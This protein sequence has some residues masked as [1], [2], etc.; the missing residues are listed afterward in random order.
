MNRTLLVLDDEPEA[1]KG[2]QVFLGAN[3]RASSASTVASSRVQA[4]AAPIPSSTSSG[5]TYEVLCASTGEEAVQ[6]IRDRLKEGRPVAGGFFDVKLGPGMD[7]IATVAEAKK[8]DP[9]IRCAIVTAYQD[10]SVDDLHRIFGEDF[11][12]HWDYLN[13]PFSKGEIVQK[14]RQMIGAWNRAKQ[15][16]ELHRQLIGSERLAAVGQVARGIGHEF[17][18]ILL[19]IMGKADL[20]LAETDLTKVREHLQVVLK[21]SER[22]GVIVRNLQSFSKPSAKKST[23]RLT[24]PLEESLSLVRHELTKASVTVESTF[25]AGTLPTVTIDRGMFAQV[26]LNLMINAMHAMSPKGGTLTLRASPESR[27]GRAGCKVEIADSGTGISP[28]VLPRIFEPAFST[29][30]DQGSGLGLS[31][32]KEIVDAHGGELT[33]HSQPGKGATF[34]VW[35]PA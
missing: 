24:D 4:G 33:A 18:N 28:E 35:V 13:K 3:V 12:D 25:D 7:G 23:C 8:L 29:K 34:S 14:A 22:A 17:G 11:R 6:I 19:R 16:E 27:A 26:F 1:I 30:G 9:D 2:Y 21:A 32:S 5:E 31:V 20:A 10:R 15:I